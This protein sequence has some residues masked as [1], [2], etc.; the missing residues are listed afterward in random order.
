VGQITPLVLPAEHINQEGQ[1]T[2][3]AML[4]NCGV[5]DKCNDNEFPV[6]LYTGKDSDDEPTICVDGKYVIAKGVNDAGR[7]LNIVVV[8]KEKRIIRTGHFDT[9]HDG[10]IILQQRKFSYHCYSY[11][12][13]YSVSR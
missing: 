5:V 10:K 3:G 4:N 9:W 8:A 11:H 7:G 1:L 12:H 2:I 6:H 13:H